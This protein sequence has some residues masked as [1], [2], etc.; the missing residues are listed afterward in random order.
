MAIAKICVDWINIGLNS[1]CAQNI[2]AAVFYYVLTKSL[3]ELTGFHLVLGAYLI[4]Y[5]IVT[6]T[7][8]AGI[9][10]GTNVL[11]W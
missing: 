5:G 2:F 6:W 3:L 8:W 7:D 1:A 9:I 10:V 11:F 4:Q